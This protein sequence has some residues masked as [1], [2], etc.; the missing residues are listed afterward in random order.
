MANV[1]TAIEVAD[2]DGLRHPMT[3]ALPGGRR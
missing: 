1:D 3:V 2:G